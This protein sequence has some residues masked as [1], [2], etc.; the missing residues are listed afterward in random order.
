MAGSFLQWLPTRSIKNLNFLVS[1]AGCY[2]TTV[3][4]PTHSQNLICLLYDDP[5]VYLLGRGET[6]VTM[7]EVTEEGKCTFLTRFDAPGIS[8][9]VVFLPKTFV[10]VKSVEMVKG[11]RLT[12]SGVE[13]ISFTVPRLKKV[14]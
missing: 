5:V 1:A 2:L 8:Q 4:T 14:L 7:F 9:G 11:W 12:Q 3:R 6:Y 10:D 13:A